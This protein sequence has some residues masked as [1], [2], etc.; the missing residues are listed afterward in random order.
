[1]H[2]LIKNIYQQLL[3]NKFG[4]SLNGYSKAEVDSFLEKI[5]SQVYFLLQDS[6]VTQTDLDKKEK[7]IEQQKNKIDELTFE[8]N[9]LEKQIRKLEELNKGI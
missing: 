4:S 2:D 9:R 7:I 3:E 1:M 5:A 8:N 6:N